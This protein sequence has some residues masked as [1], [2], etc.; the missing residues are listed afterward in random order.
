MR[1]AT[2]ER[3][4]EFPVITD[5]LPSSPDS[6]VQLLAGTRREKMAAGVKLGISVGMGARDGVGLAM[7]KAAAASANHV[8]NL[9][10]RGGDGRRVRFT[11][12]AQGAIA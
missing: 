9:R 5:R 4:H 10:Y 12:L 8:A 7:R 6:D 2:G 1:L 3:M 11:C